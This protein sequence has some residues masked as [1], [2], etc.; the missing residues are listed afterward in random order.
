MRISFTFFT[1]VCRLS[2]ALFCTQIFTDVRRYLPT[3]IVD[4]CL[5]YEYL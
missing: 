2:L 1:E 4:T 3:Y 5:I